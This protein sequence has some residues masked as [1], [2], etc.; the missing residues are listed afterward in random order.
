MKS[1]FDMIGRTMWETIAAMSII[2]LLTVGFVK[3]A[4]TVM[5]RYK[6]SRIGQQVTDLQ[7]AI[8]FRYMSKGRYNGANL[9]KMA[10]EGAVPYEVKNGA[11]AFGG[12]IEIGG[13]VI[14]QKVEDAET[15]DD[16]LLT[17]RRDYI[18]FTDVP[19]EACRS[20]SDIVWVNEGS[21]SLVAT[22]FGDEED[23]KLEE[24]SNKQ[25]DDKKMK[26]GEK[27]LVS[28]STPVDMDTVA[29]GCNEH[30]VITWIFE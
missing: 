14:D 19:L 11:H 22:Y 28:Y 12:T 2:G 30:S 25:P 24:A 27:C 13:I 18:R 21:S 29:D 7:K 3:L 8:N 1:K 9:E 23:C 4:S 17:A 5:E 26:V 16:N 20:L 10:E 6:L 15:Y